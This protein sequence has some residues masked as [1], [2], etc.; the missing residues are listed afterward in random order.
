[1]MPVPDFDC[2]SFYAERDNRTNIALAQP[3]DAV[4]LALTITPPLAE[5]VHG[6]LAL[7]W[8]SSMVARMGQRYNQ[9]QFFLPRG[10]ADFPS[11]LPGLTGVSLADALLAH[12][13]S[14]D[15]CGSYEVVGGIQEGSYVVA[16]GDPQDKFNG[17]VVRPTGWSAVI[18]RPGS[19]LTSSRPGESSNPIGAALAA[20][21]GAAEIYRYFNR[22]GLGG[23]EAQV[24][25]WISA[26]HPAV[27]RTQEEASL[28]PEDIPLPDHIDLGRWLIAGAGAL[29]GNALVILGAMADRLSGRVDVVDH[30]RVDVSN[31]N[32]LV[33]ALFEHVGHHKVE[34]AAACLQGS[35]V[36]VVPHATTY[37]RLWSAPSGQQVLPVEDYNLVLTGV[38]QM[39]TRAFVQSD[40]PRLLIRRR[41][42]QLHLARFH[43]PGGFCRSL[44]RLPRRQESEHL[45]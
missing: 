14:A 23:R 12:L 7:H 1:M 19:L 39:A 41:H 37:E 40:W 24:P 36:E 17:A 42:P 45:P 2:A 5:T 29:G 21:L 3:P 25:L 30:D 20:A 31:L 27:A 22:E 33:A 15:P 43:S 18:A 34:L 44:R 16:V 6:Q 10:V 35:S 11:R 32:R 28:W 9:L 4:R 13:Q 38:D 8:M 26:R